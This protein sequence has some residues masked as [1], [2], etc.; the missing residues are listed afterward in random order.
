MFVQNFLK[1]FFPQFPHGIWIFTEKV[2]EYI[3]T[4]EENKCCARTRRPCVSRQALFN[5]VVLDASIL[6]IAMRY[7]EDVNSGPQQ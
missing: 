7:R 4:Q 6:D 3:P 5:Q 2:N 1:K